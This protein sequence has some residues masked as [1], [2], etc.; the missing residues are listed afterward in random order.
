M[1]RLH[2]FS[3]SQFLKPNVSSPKDIP[4][5]VQMNLFRFNQNLHL[6]IYIKL[7]LAVPK[8]KGE[9]MPLNNDTTFS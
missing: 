8:L 4:I 9:L 2:Q 6:V 3:L 7:K 1:G 5:L